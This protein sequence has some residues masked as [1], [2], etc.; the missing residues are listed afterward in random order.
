MVTGFIRSLCE[1]TLFFPWAVNVGFHGIQ[2]AGSIKERF[3]APRFDTSGWLNPTVSSLNDHEVNFF[4]RLILERKYDFAIELGAYDLARSKKLKALF[5]A[6]NVFAVDITEDFQD[7]KI[8]DGVSTGPY[9]ISQIEA[10][11][12]QSQGRGLVCS[13]GTLTYYGADELVS[14]LKASFRLGLDIALV[15]P[16][17]IRDFPMKKPWSRSAQTVYHRYADL[18]SDAGYD[19]SM[20]DD[21]KDRWRNITG[22]A[23]AWSYIFAKR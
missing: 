8:V 11:A 15:E 12:L 20:N 1:R 4:A 18:L 13:N 16:C 9:N 2:I 6:L 19:L 22:R 10:I 21:A 5:P 17:C 3:S 7:S 23:E 14:L